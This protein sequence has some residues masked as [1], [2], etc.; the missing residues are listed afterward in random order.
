VL[1]WVGWWAIL[2]ARAAPRLHVCG[3]VCPVWA[4]FF[5]AMQQD[6]ATVV[7]SPGAAGT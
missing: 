7:D 5:E 6:G 1:T 2:E 4:Y 3:E